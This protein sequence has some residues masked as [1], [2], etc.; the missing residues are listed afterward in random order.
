MQSLWIN[1]SIILTIPEVNDVSKHKIDSRI[2]LTVLNSSARMYQS[3][4][5]F[6]SDVSLVLCRHWNLVIVLRFNHARGLAKGKASM[7]Y[8]L[9][10]SEHMMLRFYY[11]E[12]AE[13][14]RSAA[15]A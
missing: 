3:A 9:K 13:H 4:K 8:K 10:N 1:S 2:L 14:L 6:T 5:G 11:G 12:G 15:F 7:P